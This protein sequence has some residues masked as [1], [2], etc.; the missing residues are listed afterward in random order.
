MEIS[1]RTHRHIRSFYDSYG[2]T[3]QLF[4]EELHALVDEGKVR[5][6]DL[7][8]IKRKFPNQQPPPPRKSIKSPA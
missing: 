8:E 4:V 2:H 5:A 7:E 6:D 1:E 3:Y